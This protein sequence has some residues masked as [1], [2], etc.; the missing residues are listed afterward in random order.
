[1]FLGRLLC[2]LMPDRTAPRGVSALMLLH[3]SR[4]DSRVSAGGE[5]VLLE[6][7]DRAGWDRAEIDEGLA[8]VEAAPRVGPPD[9]YSIQAAIA[10]LHARAASAVTRRRPTLI[11][12]RWRWSV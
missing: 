11:A 9:A 7:Q 5:V 10:A 2:E 8:L 12:R 3:D 1:V 6:N 4:R